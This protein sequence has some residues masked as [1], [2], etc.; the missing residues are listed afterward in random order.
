MLKTAISGAALFAAV[1]SHADAATFE[2]IKD[3][4]CITSPLFQTQWSVGEQYRDGNN[5]IVPD[6]WFMLARWQGPGFMD[7]S[8]NYDIGAYTNL[9][10]AW[11]KGAQPEDPNGSPGVQLNCY[12]VGMLINSWG[13][14]HRPIVG[15]GFNDM[16]GYAFSAP[17]QVSPFTKSGLATDLVLQSNIAVPIFSAVHNR[18]NEAG[19]PYVISGQVTFFAYLHDTTNPSYPPIA[20]I[21]ATHMSNLYNPN[22]GEAGRLAAL[23]HGGVAVDYGENATAYARDHYPNWFAPG[24]TGSGIWYAGAALSRQNDQRYV[25]VGYTEATLDDNMPVHSDVTGTPMPFYRAH[26]TPENMRHIAE[27]INAAVACSGCPPRPPGNPNGNPGNYS[28][29]PNNWVLEYAGVIAENALVSED[30]GQPNP[31]Y[32]VSASSWTGLNTT[33]RYHDNSRDQVAMAVH[34]SGVGIYRYYP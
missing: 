24:Q 10:G 29:D 21:A 6:K 5:G 19:Q 34:L 2:T 12:D 17:N 20:V 13:S 33:P 9:H 8:V 23:A 3:P 15:G 30:P 31:N 16:W 4:I 14:A 11:Q 27:D 22:D 32:D 26:I 18:V 28:T 25:S 1:V 7:D